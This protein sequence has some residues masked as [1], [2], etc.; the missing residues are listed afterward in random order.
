[1]FNNKKGNVLPSPYDKYE[2]SALPSGTVQIYQK[3]ERDH[4]T[5]NHEEDNCLSASTVHF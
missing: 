3:R 4:T 5:G 1:M 2:V